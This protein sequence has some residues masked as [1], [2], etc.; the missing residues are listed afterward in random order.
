M[1][2]PSVVS[3]LPAGLE[4]RAGAVGA[5]GPELEVAQGPAAGTR[6][7]LRS[8]PLVLGRGESGVGTLGEDPELSR[9]HA[10]IALRDGGVVVEDLGSTNGTQVNGRQISEPTPAGPDD[11]IEVG[12]SVLRLK[13][14]PAGV[15]GVAVQVVS[16][17]AAGTRIAVAGEPVVF[18]RA[19]TG[20]GALGG[21]PE[22]SRRHAAASLLDAS[23][24]LV[25]DLG[26]TNGTFVNEHR[27]GAPTV[28]GPGDALQLGGTALEVV[29]R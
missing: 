27:I 6:I 20:D 10:S 19:E 24:L 3:G 28:V 4:R 21:D 11:S 29:E 1:A 18:G 9:R 26:S 7:P 2:A 12:S 15:D 23:R 5:A 25:E 16:G 8:E 22:L 17:P 14:A 13:L